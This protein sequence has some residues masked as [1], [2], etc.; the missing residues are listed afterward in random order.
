MD[1]ERQEFVA[2][3]SHEFQSPLTLMKGFS[4]ILL[5]GSLQD[6]ERS[7]ALQII[8][9]ESERLS[10]LSDNLLRLAALESERYAINPAYF[11]LAE[12]IRRTVLTFEPL[13]SDKQLELFIRPKRLKGEDCSPDLLS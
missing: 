5:E 9:Q 1:R 7:R 3:V 8:I 12:Q 6:S 4:A 2:N 13:W 11:D 10:R